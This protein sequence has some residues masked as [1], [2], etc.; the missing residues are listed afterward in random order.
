MHAND[1][2][3]TFYCIAPIGRKS[4]TVI[5]SQKFVVGSE[6]GE[7][8]SKMDGHGFVIPSD[9]LSKELTITYGIIPFGKVACHFPKRNCAGFKWMCT[10]LKSVPSHSFL[11][12][13]RRQA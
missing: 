11:P 8:A 4:S 12:I 1:I 3:A 9:V 10:L 6:G 2:N 5:Q 13:K 7:Y